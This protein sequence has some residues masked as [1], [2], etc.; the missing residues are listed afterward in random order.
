MLEELILSENS[1]V[2]L[3]R[4]VS[5]MSMLRILKIQNNCL[6]AIP[7]SL[8]DVVTLEDLVRYAMAPLTLTIHY[9]SHITH[10]PG[11]ICIS[12]LTCWITDQFIR[13]PLRISVQ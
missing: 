13:S 2:E 12:H 1:L 4:N 8:V 9:S 11:I 7:F 5:S 10:L 6:K 3:P